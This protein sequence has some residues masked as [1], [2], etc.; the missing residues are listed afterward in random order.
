MQLKR[1]TIK[2]LMLTAVYILKSVHKFEVHCIHI[3]TLHCAIYM[4][5]ASTLKELAQF[6][7]NDGI[8]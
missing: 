7:F 3:A 1:F 8:I 2:K 4:Y 5:V 6:T